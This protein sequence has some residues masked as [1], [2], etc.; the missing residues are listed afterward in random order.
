MR[1]RARVAS[2]TTSRTLRS[3]KTSPPTEL[4]LALP[5][6]ARVGGRL[7]ARK[8]K[9]VKTQKPSMTNAFC[10]V[11]CAG[12]DTWVLSDRATKL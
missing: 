7:G 9:N 3:R 12:L 8:V 10:V 6:E 2:R 1:L 4:V 5:P 11:R